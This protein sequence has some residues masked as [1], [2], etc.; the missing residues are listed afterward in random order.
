[1]CFGSFMMKERFET[2]KDFAGKEYFP[3]VVVAV[4]EWIKDRGT[5]QEILCTSD[6]VA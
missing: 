4:V 5:T 1:M 6:T 2:K 3:M